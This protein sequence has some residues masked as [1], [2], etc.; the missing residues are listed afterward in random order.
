MS[1][2]PTLDAA[3]VSRRIV[4]GVG[5]VYDLLNELNGL[6]RMTLDGLRSSEMEFEVIMSKFFRMPVPRG[7][8]RSPADKSLP[9]D[10]GFV[11]N[12]GVTG[13]DEEDE[14]GED[15]EDAD[16]SV[17]AREKRGLKI[18][19]ESHFLALRVVLYDR[20]QAKG[21][22]FVP[23][24]VA[25]TLANMKQ[26]P[27]GKAAQKKKTTTT[28]QV[29]QGRLLQLA[30]RVSPSVSEGQSLSFR[31]GGHESV[32][33]VTNIISRPLAK[34]DSEKSVNS[35]VEELVQMAEGATT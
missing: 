12:L 8:G 2:E 31:A 7:G 19:P 24:V 28:F 9:L 18:T 32:C 25:A 34:F 30:K 35:F 5:L 29:T 27:K 17:S 3:E 14:E 1:D 10:R 13:N 20:D 4:V 21:G 22:E 23:A 26:I 6:L 11:L 33:T 15:V 16:E